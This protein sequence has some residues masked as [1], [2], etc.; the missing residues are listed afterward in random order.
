MA[1]PKHDRAAPGRAGKIIMASLTE[2]VI[3]LLR[4]APQLP[5]KD[6]R[7]LDGDFAMPSGG[8]VRISI[9]LNVDLP[10]EPAQPRRPLMI[11][12]PK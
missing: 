1:A 12:G 8:R 6:A 5:T 2:Q 7:W 11:E 10:E 3:G 9:M 4:E